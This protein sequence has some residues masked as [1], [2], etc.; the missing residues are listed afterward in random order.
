AKELSAKEE[1]LA[2]ALAA[3]KNATPKKKEPRVVMTQGISFKEPSETTP[4]TALL[5]SPKLKDKGKAIM[6]EEPLKMKRKDQILYDEQEA[7]RLHEQY[8]EEA[9]IE[10]EKEGRS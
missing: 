8:D 5:S 1:T 6:E 7:L 9:R 2:Q 4:T 10:R 3:L